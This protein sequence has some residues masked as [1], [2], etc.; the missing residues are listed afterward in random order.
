M[1]LLSRLF[2]V[3]SLF[4]HQSFRA[5]WHVTLTAGWQGSPPA[6]TFRNSWL[7]LA[8]CLFRVLA[9][10]GMRGEGGWERGWGAQRGPWLSPGPTWS[11]EECVWSSWSS[12]TRCS[13][14]VLVQ[15]RYRHQRPAPGGAG[16]G[17]PCTRLDGHFRPCLT[18]NCSGEAPG[19]RSR[20]DEPWQ[21]PPGVPRG[22]RQL[23][24]E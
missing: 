3:F 1:H 19:A 9:G 18:G 4:H 23:L 21:G 22:H 11:L 17:P 15:Q 16:A 14:E 2:S 20:G 13:C 7:P 10:A 24:L 5:L 12:W 6:G 8:L